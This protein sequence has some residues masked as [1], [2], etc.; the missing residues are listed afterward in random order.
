MLNPWNV[1]QALAEFL[2]VL[3]RLVVTLLLTGG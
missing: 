2:V 1:Y 3:A